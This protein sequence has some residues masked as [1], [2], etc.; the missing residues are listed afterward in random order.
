MS[1]VT[2]NIAD[3]LRP[4]FL[5]GARFEGIYDPPASEGFVEVIPGG[6]WQ[7]L[8][9]PL[10]SAEARFLRVY[11]FGHDNAD[12]LKAHWR[13]E[14]R[15]LMRLSARRHPSLP[16][17]RDA[18]ILAGEALGYLILDDPGEAVRGDHPVSSRIRSE[19]PRTLRDFL[20]LVEGVSLLHRDG[21]V[22][23][24]ITPNSVCA[25][26]TPDAAVVLD[27]FQMSAFVSTWLRGRG[28]FEDWAPGSFLP[29]SAWSRAFMAPERLAPLFGGQTKRLEGYGTDVFS[30]GMLGSWW[31]VGDEPFRD[32]ASVFAED[33]Y[34]ESVHQ[35][36]IK[37]VHSTLRKSDIPTMLR[38]LL[39]EMTEVAPANR[40]P[41][42]VVAYEALSKMYGSVLAWFETTADEKP[43][44]LHLYYL[45]ES[46]ERM[47]R[48]GLA[49]SPPEDP[50]FQEY[51]DVIERDVVDGILTWCDD[52]FRRWQTRANPDAESARVVLIGKH[53]THFCQYLN[54]GFDNEDRRVLMVRF[55]LPNHRAT[56]L[57]RQPLQRATPPLTVAYFSPGARMRP[58]P[59][60][61]RS[62]QQLVESV[63]SS[64][65]ADAGTL[66]ERTGRWLLG[67]DSGRSLAE[68][69][70]VEVLEESVG[71]VS[72]RSVERS[73]DGTD[74]DEESVAFAN[75]WLRVRERS[76]MGDHFEEFFQTAIEEERFVKFEVVASPGD[77][78]HVALLRFIQKLDADTVRF[79]VE[80]QLGEIPSE[81]WVRPE[82]IA[83]QVVSQRHRK[84]LVVA[85]E[86][87]Q[88]N[89]Q[90]RAPR[91]VSVFTPS[92]FGDAA[93]DVT[94]EGTQGLLRKMLCAWPI[95]L[96][97]GPPG[98]GKTFLAAH[99]IAE[100]LRNDPFAR[101]LVSAQS[102]HALDNLLEQVS[103]ILMDP[104]WST[105][106]LGA[107]I[108]LRISSDATVDKVGH[109][110]KL[111]L[112]TKI[113]QSVIADIKAAELAGT[114]ELRR[115]QKQ[116]RRMSENN[117]LDVDIGQRL[118]RAASVTC[119]SSNSATTR[120]LRAD[121]DSGS[122]DLVV[123]E[124]AARGWLTEAL[125]P[126]VHANRW[127]LVGDQ[128]QLPAYA[129]TEVSHA[130]SIDVDENLTG[131]VT[132]SPPSAEL[133]PY[134]KWFGSLFE[135]PATSRGRQIDPR[136][137]LLVQRRMHPDIGNLI[138]R[139][140][141]GGRLKN[142]SSTKRA[143][144]LK[145]LPFHSDTAFIWVDTSPLG[146]EAREHGLTNYCECQVLRMLIAD[147][148]RDFPQHDQ[149]IPAVCLLT[150]YRDQ[151]K[152]LIQVVRTLPEEA[153]ATVHAFQGR[154]AEVVF[155]S[156]TRNN[157]YDASRRALGFLQAPEIGNVM[158]SRA[159]RLL[160]VVGSLEHFAR[161]PETHWE[162]VVR[163]VKSDSRFYFDPTEP[164]MSFRAVWRRQ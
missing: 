160:V 26:R 122:Y 159:R 128:E 103:D 57:R 45:Y 72:L 49:T 28:A 21:M 138:S 95:F 106:S 135:A 142:H 37:G 10:G 56:E 125:V 157:T 94:D 2:D 43:E 33:R 137:V 54:Q 30:L 77:T 3:Q 143:H 17:M 126:M 7:S 162:E 6:V 114:K 117:Q 20:S 153:F 88:L 146:E 35:E 78:D 145:G 105:D 90:L 132:D 99:F 50:D 116:W 52:G 101:I 36:L 81:A 12:L 107:A 61:A 13:N 149:S 65:V 44:P 60:S 73:F 108:L 15:A 148:I 18:G 144:C 14:V 147:Y 130:L 23:R 71:M 124:E 155:V 140:F 163:Y 63:R 59:R 1:K 151:R 121:Y 80:S 62:W 48:D 150:P 40:V 34:H 58:I 152:K 123:L 115:L 75:L 139:S 24:T 84:A 109:R 16:V 136:E 164:E 32:A 100:L 79:E 120:N 104:R 69:Y 9:Y 131:P 119:V 82:D 161:F 96:V 55:L 19:R 53:Y 31:F 87:F 11:Q 92:E 112:P 156:L 74:S 129:A 97:Q 76:T 102:H 133:K 42:A 86:N 93:Q 127:L 64:E 68:T 22:H 154:Q 85:G 39:V 113:L 5:A 70:P 41:S 51:T 29:S 91:A 134:L 47:H 158:F 118:H 67:L 141:Y 110:G 111:Y 27:G 8:V 66:M 46:V 4:H 89:A 83:R 25:R 98:T 38:R